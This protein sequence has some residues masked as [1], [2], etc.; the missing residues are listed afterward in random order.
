LAG[1][2]SAADSVS[3]RKGQAGP[4][5][6]AMSLI[7][8]TAICFLACGFYLCVLVHWVHETQREKASR[9]GADDETRQGR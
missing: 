2:V 6:G 5:S 8:L 7:V 9:L 3:V 1:E 4:A